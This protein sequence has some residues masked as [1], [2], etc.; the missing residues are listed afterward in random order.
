MSYWQFVR[1]QQYA[2]LTR[3]N[4]GRR[5][6]QSIINHDP[7]WDRLAS[8]DENYFFAS[9]DPWLEQQRRQIELE[10][11]R[12]QNLRERELIRSRK[13]QK[14]LERQKRQEKENHWGECVFCLLVIVAVILIISMGNREQ[15]QY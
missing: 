3:Y 15:S 8:V 4:E 2:S 14:Q 12:Q 6:A 1:D 9:M 5:F 11:L 13:R 10:Q 7:A